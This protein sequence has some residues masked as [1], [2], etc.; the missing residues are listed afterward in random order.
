MA[1]KFYTYFIFKNAIR[2]VILSLFCFLNTYELAY[3]AAF[4]I[5]E[6]YVRHLLPTNPPISPQEEY[7]AKNLQTRLTGYFGAYHVLSSGVIATAG[8]VLK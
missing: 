4:P 6:R 1:V 2:P 5:D 3:G 7:F 8:Q